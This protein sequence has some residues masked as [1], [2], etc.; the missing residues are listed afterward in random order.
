MAAQSQACVFEAAGEARLG[1]HGV[2]ERKVEGGGYVGGAEAT[3]GW[4]ANYQGH[5]GVSMAELGGDR[6]RG[7]GGSQGGGSDEDDEVGGVENL[8]G[9]GAVVCGE[10]TNEEI[11]CGAG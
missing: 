2:Q 4:A 7:G 5:V 3:W 9:V 8:V 10:V 6:F 11:A 1:T